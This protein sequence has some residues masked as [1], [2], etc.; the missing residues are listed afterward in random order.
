[1]YC[2]SLEFNAQHNNLK[3]PEEVP[4]PH[5]QRQASVL[6]QPCCFKEQA[7]DLIT[8]QLFHL[9]AHEA[10]IKVHGNMRDC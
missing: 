10:L 3:K 1:M 6:A 4:V 2:K 9:A 5:G 8:Q 7:E